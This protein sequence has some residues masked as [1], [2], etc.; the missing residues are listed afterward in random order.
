MHLAFSLAGVS[1]LEE[2]Q[3]LILQNTYI[4]SPFLQR[5]EAERFEEYAL[6]ADLS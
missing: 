6:R 2:K 1:R 5:W 4:P 3:V